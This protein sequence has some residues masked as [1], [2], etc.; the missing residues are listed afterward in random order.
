VKAMDN[1][2]AILKRY[3]GEAKKRNLIV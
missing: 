1:N 2:A 3:E